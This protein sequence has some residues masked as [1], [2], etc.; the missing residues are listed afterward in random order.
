MIRLSRDAGDLGSLVD[1]MDQNKLVNI[2]TYT[3]KFTNDPSQKFLLMILCSQAKLENDN[4]SINVKRGLKAKVELGLWPAQAPTGYI[5]S[6]DRKQTG[7]VL[8]DPERSKMVQEIFEHM[9]YDNWSGFK[10]HEWLTKEKNF[11]TMKGKHLSKGNLYLLIKNS[12]YYGEFEYP[13]KSGNWYKGVHTPLITKELFD[14]V[15]KNIADNNQGTGVRNKEFAFTKMITC[16][17]CGSGIS[18][19]EK[20][21]NLKNGGR[22]RHVYY[23]CSRSRDSACHNRVTESELISRLKYLIDTIDLNKLA[24]KDKI[25]KEVV[26]FKR[27]QTRLLKNKTQVTIKEIDIREYVKFVLE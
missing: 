12:F 26:R 20:F 18:A 21:K 11:K 5:S 10:T 27:F 9:G 2:Q 16:G 19:E 3:Q 22:S 17:N 8:P 7:V 15:Q 6:P 4:K 25:Q 24:L 14:L 1:L 13:V 23:K